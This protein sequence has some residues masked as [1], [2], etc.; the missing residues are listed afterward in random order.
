MKKFYKLFLL[1]IS[2]LFIS[3]SSYSQVNDIKFSG[4]QPSC[5]MQSDGFI[6]FE[7]FGVGAGTTGPGYSFTFGFPGTPPTRIS[8]NVGDTIKNLVS[9]SYFIE[10][11]DNGVYYREDTT[12]SFVSSISSFLLPT[13]ESCFG[14]GDGMIS[15][16]PNGGNGAPFTYQWDDPAM[17]TTKDISGLSSGGYNVTITDSKG[18]IATATDTIRSNPRV[19]ANVMLDSIDCNGGT[20]TATA[21][22]SGGTGMGYMYSWSST[23]ANNTPIENGLTGTLAG[24][25]YTVT[26]TDSDGCTGTES[27]TVIEPAGLNVTIS[28]DSVDCFGDAT[29]AATAAVSG[30]TSPYT[31]TW[32]ATGTAAGNMINGLTAGNYNVTVDDMNGCRQIQAFMIGSETE[33]IV[34]LDSTDV[35]CNGNSTGAVSITISGASPTYD[36]IW[37]DGTSGTNITSGATNTTNGLTAGTYRVT[38]TDDLGCQKI[39]SIVVNE[40]TPLSLMVSRTQDPFCVGGMD[41]E[42]DITVSGGVTPYSYLWNDGNTSMNR[43][44]LSAGTYTVVV[45]DAN[46]CTISVSTTLSNPAP[47]LPNVTTTDTK[48]RGGADGTATATPSGGSGTYVNYTWSSSGNTTDTETG[49][50]QGTY[51]VTVTDSD[52]CTGRETFTI[53]EPAVA[54]TVNVTTTDAD[55]NGASTGTATANPAGGAAP[56]TF[57]WNG[58]TSVAPNTT[59]TGLAAGNYDVTATDAN[60]CEL[61]IPFVINEPTGMLL[62]LDSTDVDCFG[63]M[64]GSAR[65]TITSGTPNYS[66]IWSSGDA[67]NNIPDGG[68]ASANNLVAGMYRIT[69]TDANGCQK[70]D[71]IRVNEPTDLV[72]ALDTKSDPLCTADMNGSITILVSGGT[73]TYNFAWSDGPTVQNRT[74]LTAGTYTVVVTDLNGCTE[75]FTETLSDPPAFTAVIDSLEDVSCNGFTDGFARVLASGGTGAYTYD[76]GGGVTSA[77]NPN[78]APGTYT[79]TVLDANSCQTTATATIGEPT[80]ITITT[81]STDASC[82]GLNDGTA[83]ANPLGGTGRYTYQW[84]DMPAMQTTQTANNLAA[85]TYNVTVTDENGCQQTAT[86]TVNQPTTIVLSTAV[87]DALCNGDS[88][89]T[90]TVSVTGGT[91]TLTYQWDDIPGMQ[92]TQTATNLPAGTYNVIVTDANGCNETATATITEPTAVVA[93]ISSFTNPTC[94]GINDGSATASGTGGTVAGN[95]SYL[96]S[97]N[98][99][100]QTAVNLPGGTYTVTVTDDNMCSDTVSVTL[101][102]P[103]SVTVVIDSIANVDCFGASTG[104]IDITVSGGT[105]PYTYNWA[106]GPTSEDRSNLT[107]G[108]YDLVITDNRGCMDN[109]SFVITQP[110]NGM[111]ATFNVNDVNCNG[112]SDGNIKANVTGGSQPYSFNWEGNPMGSPNDSIF[113]LVANTYRVTITDNNGCSLIDSATVAEPTAISINVLN[114]TNVDCNGDQTG[115]ITVGATGGVAPYVYQWNNAPTNTVGPTVSN[116]G[117]GV[118]TVTITD[119]N[120][121]VSTLQVTITESTLLSATLSTYDVGCGTTVNGSAA[122]NATGGTGILTYSWFPLGVSGQGTDSIFNLSAGNYSLTVTDAL[123]CD[124]IQNFTINSSVSSFTFSDSIV[125]DSCGGTCNGSIE[126][127][128]LAGGSSPYSY[129]WS[130]G[131][132]TAST[133]NL[134]AGSYT[135]TISD[136]SGCDTIMS[137][138]ITEPTDLAATVITTP[139]T[140]ITGLGTATATNVSGGLAPYTYTWPG[141]GTGNSTS[142]LSANGYDL[143]ITDANSCQLLVPFVIGNVSPFDINF[144][145]NDVTCAGFSNGSINVVT[146]GAVLPATYNWEDGLAGGSNPINL[147]GGSYE[148]TV[149]DANGCAAIDTAIVDEPAVL[150]VDFLTVTPET[151]VPGNDGD[152][153]VSVSGGVLP[154]SYDWGNGFITNNTIS[155]LTAGSYTLTIQDAN[156]CSTTENFIVNSTAPF[157]VVPPVVTD[158]S[159]NGGTDGSITLSLTGA[160]TPVTYTWDP[161]LP[162]SNVQT[163]L[164]NGVYKVTITDATTCSETLSILVNEANPIVTSFSNLQDESCSPGVDG[165]AVISVS[166]GVQPYTYDWD[167]MIIDGA[168]TDSVYNLTAGF[169]SVT[170]TDANMCTKV[171]PF[172][173]NSAND[174]DPNPL[175]T[176][177]T[178]F[179]DNDGSLTLNP[180]GGVAPYT[181]LWFDGTTSATKNNLSAGS[182]AVTITDA[183]TPPCVK[184]TS[185]TLN[186]PSPIG[187][188]LNTS[189]ES[190]VPGNDGTAVFGING[191][192]APFTYAYSGGTVGSTPNQLEGLS[193]GNYSITVTDAN[194]CQRTESFT[195]F[196]AQNFTLNLDETDPTC[197]NGNDGAFIVTVNGGT[198]PLSYNWSGGLTDANPSSVSAGTYTITVTD[199]YGCTG[200]E[201]GTLV[202]RAPITASI[203]ITDET[204]VPGND[205]AAVA[206]AMGGQGDY[207]YAWPT[208]GVVNQNQITGLSA[209][210]YNLTITDDS[211]CVSIIPFV[212]GSSAPFT[213]TSVVDSVNCKAGNDGSIDLTVT[214][215]LG[216]LTYQWSSNVNGNVTDPDQFNLTAGTY[217]V[218]ITDAGNNCIETEIFTVQEPDTLV[219]TANITPVGCSPTGNDG[220]IDL[221]ILGGTASY[222][223]LWDDGTT[224][225][226][227]TML[228]VG[229]YSVTI[230]DKYGCAINESYQ[231]TNQQLITA[232]LDSTDVSCNGDMNG[233]VTVTTTNAVTP[234]Y[235]WSDGTNI[236]GK[237][238]SIFGLSGGTYYVTVTDATTTCVGVDSILV[239]ERTAITTTFSIMDESCFPGN[240]GAVSANSTGGLPGYAYTFSAGNVIANSAVNGLQ[241]GTYTVTIFDQAGCSAT[242]NFTVGSTAPFNVSFNTTEPTCAG[243]STGTAN[244]T[245]V[246]ATGSPTFMWPATVANPTLKD[247]T[248]LPAGTYTVT[249]TDPIS[250]CTETTPITITE[251]DS[252]KA[253]AVITPENCNPGMNGSIDITVTG[254]DGGPYN[255]NWSG[256]ANPNSQN[257]NNLST[258]KYIVTITD[259]NL[260]EGVDSF[261]VRSILSTVPNLTTINDGCSPLSVCVGSATVAPT[262]GV[263]PY[264][265]AWSGPNGPISSTM[266]S[267]SSICAGAYTVTITDAVGCDTIVDFNIGA[268]RIIL[269]NEL[270]KNESCNIDNDGEISVTP[271]GGEAPYT[272]NWSG[273]TITDSVRTS[274]SPGV[275]T[276]TITD[277]TGCDT[278]AD[279]TVGTEQFD[280]TVNKT[281]LSCSGLCDGS[282]GISIV[283]GNAGF[284]F[285]WSPIPGSNDG[286]GN[287]ADLCDGTY[288]VTITNTANGCVKTEQIVVNPTSPIEPNETI[289]DEGCN[290]AADGSITLATIGGAGNYT[291]TWSPNVSTTSSAT[292]LSANTY[293]ITITDAAGCD[294][295]ITAVVQAGTQLNGNVLV[296]NNVTCNSS[297]LCDGSAFVNVSNGTAPYNY[298]WGAGVTVTTPDSAINL[299]PGNYSVTV[300]DASGCT[301]AFPFV[302]TG[303]TALQPNFNNSNSTCSVSNGVLMAAP[304][305]GTA[306]YTVEWFDNN[307]T[308]IGTTLSISSL[309]AGF[310]SLEITDA[311]GCQETFNTAIND[312]GAEI[313]S[314]SF[315][316]VSC[317]N[318][319]DGSATVTFTCSDPGCRVEWFSTATMTSIA[320]TRTVTGLTAG[321]Y[322]VEVTNFNS[323]LSVESVTISEPIGFQVFSSQTDNV[324]EG[325]N[326]G[327]INLNVTGGAGTYTY[328]WSPAPAVGQ[329][330]SNVSG[331]FANNYFVTV[332]DANGCD[333]ILDFTI[334]EPNAINVAFTSIDA[335]C[336]M[337]D[338]SITANVTG[339]TVI[340]DYTYEWFD[341]NNSLLS[342]TTNVLANIASGSYRLRV[343]DDNSCTANF[344]ITISDAN[345]PTVNVDS[346]LNAGCFGEANGGVFITPSGTNSPFTFNWLPNGETSEDIMNLPAG[347]YSVRVTDALGC[348]TVVSDTVRES[349]EILATI[350]RNDATCGQC[351][352][353]ANITVTGGTAPYN[354]LWSNGSTQ[355]SSMNLCGGNYSVIVTDANG[356]S[357]TIDFGV[358]TVGGPTGETVAI[359]PASCANSSDGS[360]T[361]TPIGG[362]PPYTYSWLHNSN[363]TSN[364]LNNLAAG[365]YFFQFSDARS[366]SRTVEIEITSPSEIV[367]SQQIVAAT[368]G[369]NTDGSINLIVSGGLAPYTY[370]WG[371]GFTVDTNYRDNLAAGIYNVNITDANGCV[372]SRT[373]TVS[374]S[375]ASATTSPTVGNISCYGTC[376]GTLTSNIISST[377]VDFVWLNATGNEIGALNTDLTGVCAGDYILELRTNPQGCKSYIRVTVSEPDSITLSSSVVNNVSCNGSCDGEVFINTRGGNILYSYS[378]SDP[379]N[380][381]QIP[382]SGLCAGTYTVTATDAN[383]CTKTTSVSLT[384]PTPL[385]VNI[386]S[387]TNLNCSSDCDATATSVAT[388]GRAPY[389]YTWSGG[390]TGANPTN[391]C[392]GEN[393]LTVTDASNCIVTTSVMISA[394]DTV[395]A[396]AFG[397]NVIC[398]GTFIQLDGMTTGNS[399]TSSGW[400]LDDG[401]TLF[402]TTED[403]TFLRA[404]GDYTFLYV[405]ASG[406]CSDTA[407]YN[408]KVAALPL[409]GLADQ[410]S[411]I[412][413]DQTIIEL[414]GDNPAYSYIWTP[415]DGLND[416]SLAEPTTSIR[417]D[418]TYIV[419]VTDTNGCSFVDSINVTYSPNIEI[420]SGIT[421]NGDGKNDVW[422]IRYLNDFPTA[423]VQIYN[424]WG[425][426][427]YE[428]PNGYLKPWDGTYEGKKLPI[429]TYYYVI[430]LKDDRFSPLTGP[431]TIV[432]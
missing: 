294:T 303:P 277:A 355:T 365:T 193:A 431:I 266:N 96:W 430:D 162:N 318:G 133:I 108:T 163:N 10:I 405:A 197:A 247:Q 403:T 167:P 239:N 78:L 257:Q 210:N 5:F 176:P 219:A 315:N 253:T 48:C 420:P 170:I 255:F 194:M 199:L 1:S 24:T 331:L 397:P 321:D 44:G 124:S 59:T 229:S 122:V 306:P 388:G 83:T 31:Y 39:D 198:N 313:I 116:L 416:S 241:A 52:G 292:N 296:T 413:D 329:N 419:E 164:A 172:A 366:C 3:F 238:Q 371:S 92:T 110:A 359:T 45:T 14:A 245:V 226:D 32:P 374:N 338:G 84:D 302:I 372:E 323:C 87:T 21:I 406:S 130:N 347:A 286:M 183:A 203:S 293:N 289:V 49:L 27:F 324:C 185:V 240:D 25:T 284:T 260:C 42:I 270:V 364:T 82:S 215:N 178:C 367:V 280:Y 429:G 58:G 309:S 251:P 144:T 342:S 320:N 107:A 402:T 288:D 412:G 128:G 64:T 102:N 308:S 362:T 417:E 46:L 179:G 134:C 326:S 23:P 148:L 174:V 328:T 363:A 109:F 335:N 301:E 71:S 386:T 407:T 34:T 118:Y 333:T 351:N 275:Y 156:G 62:S 261:S 158:A 171:A 348:A 192:I 317:F 246:G 98:Q 208:G 336:N 217:S 370:N 382:A 276:V 2:L 38:V 70:I 353:S 121:C 191:G 113:N 287:V 169:Y 350:N 117:A 139:D 77:S 224:T 278:I 264:S 307:G 249:V 340:A 360:A 391:L 250:G 93:S 235:S 189:L 242:E 268:K 237:T 104:S 152:A 256:V 424:R 187:I 381:Q 72:V 400:Y 129:N 330:T 343:T 357:K 150:S 61:V 175:E 138:V 221:S 149:T 399:I 304:S 356:C 202:D 232:D 95:Y 66:F 259:G 168:G 299:C 57:V 427:L 115:S 155:S 332:S 395:I 408:I 244:I 112:L 205:G 40:P 392:F 13:N 73:P 377:P 76:W 231:I 262:G 20:A 327:S 361:I 354:Y 151:C 88:T 180:T 153:T 159:C 68:V 89:G 223:Y 421:P 216:A 263:A 157:T 209:G 60:G 106:D 18:C 211:M 279:I 272:Y 69:V 207:T 15:L 184:P 401:V 345:G 220:A 67:G 120:L 378:W 269:P 17:S 281:D 7:G 380:Q 37:S 36:F 258:G 387:N 319:S 146:V 341:A 325:G 222:S 173:I 218:T 12:L 409:V 99:T 196:A 11:V 131:D 132:M 295:S 393:I 75:S 50:A 63:N 28:T 114:Q 188:G 47:I 80:A 4:Q 423:S 383:G 285:A 230:T 111:Q 415:A 349:E 346:V 432:K 368:C 91:G 204:C 94:N 74:N 233:S 165:F 101:I 291:Y 385:A 376:D 300:T 344:N 390:Q 418:I 298:N 85:G 35:D 248:N 352:G 16:F 190:C 56:Y 160:T 426:L 414:T 267:I 265:F 234:Q 195:I 297:T 6:V 136:N 375:G 9:G 379:N 398:E 125:N 54:F 311:N 79:V 141:G 29:G 373:I 214:G 227:R 384:D 389:V 105:L 422:N 305:G 53:N 147:Q 143:T 213:L 181:Y 186:G 142:G 177:P 339:G 254:G 225:E 140:C 410:L 358:N 182:Y 228:T 252:I 314:T 394:I 145:I 312:N 103:P 316:D 33:L 22:P 127:I 137:Y 200:T 290:A 271:S 154:Y 119:A 97:D 166:D 396:E 404:P 90:A 322:Y 8:I 283:G 425:T 310:Y 212:I 41:G 243:D 282:I 411:L 369:V 65:A 43:T 273:T 337:S 100:T 135:V 26:I 81:T 126:I 201:I 19:V 334:T 86:A 274:L 206:T 30:G 123:G 161:V 55:C 236:I 51:T 428:Q